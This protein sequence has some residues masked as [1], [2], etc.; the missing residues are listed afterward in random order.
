VHN[1]GTQIWH[2]C[3][4]FYT[5]RN[6]EEENIYDYV[7]KKALFAFLREWEREESVRV[8]VCV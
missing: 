3:D 6:R 1:T 2:R 5:K 8:P 7:L 4:N